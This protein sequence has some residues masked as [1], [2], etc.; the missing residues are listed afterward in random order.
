MKDSESSKKHFFCIEHAIKYGV[1][2]AIL[3]Q[4][5]IFWVSK[6]RSNAK[7]FRYGRYWMYSSVRQFNTQFHPYF[8]TSQIRTGL[9]SLEKQNVIIIRELNVRNYSNPNWFTVTDQSLL[10]DFG[11]PIDKL[12]EMNRLN[13]SKLIKDNNLDIHITGLTDEKIKYEIRKALPSVNGLANKLKLDFP[14][15]KNDWYFIG[16]ENDII[17]KDFEEDV[18]DKLDESQLLEIIKLKNLTGE[19]TQ[20]MEIDDMRNIVRKELTI[21]IEKDKKNGMTIEEDVRLAQEEILKSL[22]T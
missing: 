1:K 2:E 6:N 9:K 10:E 18:V 19:P 3:L 17:F 7:N 14:D 16:D 4:N 12:D 5:I 15:A 21:L 20:D 22:L 8:S 13:L 11:L